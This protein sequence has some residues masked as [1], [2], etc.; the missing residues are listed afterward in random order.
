VA[1][2]EVG[3]LPHLIW[4]FLGSLWPGGPRPDH[5][6]WALDHL[7]PDERRLW[8]RMSGPDRRHAI[9]VAHRTIALLSDRPAPRPVV[10]AALLHDVGKVESRVGTIGRAV[11]TALAMC[12]GRQRLVA[13]EADGWRGRARA[14]LLH[15]RI[16][17][18]LLRAADSDPLTVAW[19][20]QH[21]LPPG[22]W[23]VDRRVAEALKAADGD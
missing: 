19:A 4:R 1:A 21:H 2:R 13:T 16:G 7:G 8:H 6:A 5:E 9:A 23:T 18:R 20:E 11:I 12:L 22:R 15:D 3:S 10:A 14:Y 17:G